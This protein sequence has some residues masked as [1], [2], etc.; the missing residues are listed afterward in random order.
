LAR[1]FTLS[2]N[3]SGRAGSWNPRL[4]RYLREDRDRLSAGDFR[5]DQ[6]LIIRFPD[7]SHVLFRYAFAIRDKV[8]AE[9]V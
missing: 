2:G 5:S 4:R 1:S 7:G 6:S 3:A 9:L 8:G